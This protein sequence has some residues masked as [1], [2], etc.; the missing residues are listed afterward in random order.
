MNW[1]KIIL[2][3][4]ASIIV[5]LPTL[6]PLFRQQFFHLHDFT[7]V[8]RLVE[9]DHAI[10][11]GHF[12]VRWSK[13]LGFGY[14]LP[15]FNFYAPLVYY[16][17][18]IFLLIGLSPLW[19]IKL[20]VIINFLVSFI[21]L[22]LLGELF[23]GKWAGLL[24]GTAF[25]YAPYRAVD[26]YVRG[27]IAELTAIT[28]I[29]LSLLSICYWIKK[30]TL[31]RGVF[32]SLSIGGL[33]LAHNLTA[34]MALPMLLIVLLVLTYVQFG[35]IRQVISGVLFFILGIT[36]SAFYALPALW[37]KQYTQVESLT[38]GFSDFHHHFLY[39]RQLIS[40]PWGYGGSIFGVNDDVS[41]D[42]G[43]LHIVLGTLG[44]LS[45]LIYRNNKQKL[46]NY[47]L[48]ISGIIVVVAI[49]MTTFKTQLI[50]EAIPWLKYIQFP[51]RYLSIIMVFS[52]ILVGASVRLIKTRS[53]KA[54]FTIV[55]II[56]PLPN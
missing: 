41:F 52:S 20:V 14:G 5:C 53:G 31:T 40:S 37:E 26:F 48:A 43:L 9:M 15:Q 45:L 30:P 1:K 10:Q 32:L 6:I 56:G 21:A 12:P 34:A 7:H 18:E 11:D 16:V 39:L 4:L 22:Y 25:I 2:L 55:A 17:A 51:W 36:L 23:W 13:N 44:G 49:L 8:A 24:A 50:W 27:A 54:L 33:I 29:A 35:S 47:L 19:S 28:F 38:Q 3:G 46:G 42:I